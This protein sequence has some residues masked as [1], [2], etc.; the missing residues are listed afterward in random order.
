MC[1]N[2]FLKNSDENSY[3]KNLEDKKNGLSFIHTILQNKNRYKIRGCLDFKIHFIIQ[4][5]LFTNQNNLSIK[6]EIFNILKEISLCLVDMNEINWLFGNNFD[7]VFGELYKEKSIV[8]VTL[9]DCVLY[10]GVS[11]VGGNGFPCGN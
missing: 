11:A 4:K 5:F 8:E 9:M 3:L 1:T 7:K 2:L 6:K 10:G